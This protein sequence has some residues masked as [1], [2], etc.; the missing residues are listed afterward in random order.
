[1]E[2]AEIRKNINQNPND[3]Q[4]LRGAGRYYL[5]EG[6]YKQALTCFMQATLNNPHILPKILLDYET[7]IAQNPDKTGARLSLCG[8]LLSVENTDGALLELEELLEL[9]PKNVEAYN[10][11]GMIYVKREMIDEA[12]FLLE[13]SITEGVKDVRLSETLAS[14]YLEKGRVQDAISFYEEILKQK[15]GDKQTLRIL[16]ELYA[17]QEN[18]NFAARRYEAMFSG[19][20][21]VGREVIQRLEEMLKKVEG[22]V[23]IREILALIY[24]KAL[25]PEAAVE[26]LNEI[27]RLESTKA[28]TV[29]HQLKEVLKNYPNLP[30]AMLG[31]AEALRLKRIFSEAAETY[32]QL[33][34]IKPDFIEEIIGG[35]RKILEDCP[36]QVLARLYLGEALIRQ[37]KVV[38]ALNEFG[39]M[40]DS[41][42]SA[43]E[44]VIKKCRE[45]L[46][47]DPQLVKAHI[48]L[49][50]AYLAKE[51]FE[52]AAVEA[53]GVIALDKNATAAY[54]LLGEA[55]SRLNL[56]RKAFKSL[57]TALVLE[58][59]NYHI[60]AKIQEAR[61]KEIEADIES[62][63]QILTE[64]Q[65]K[66]S[67]HFDL[68]KL[69]IE[70][71]ERDTAVRELQLAQK[72]QLRAPAALNILGNLYRSEGKYEMAVAQ[73]NR[74]LETAVLD[75][76]RTIR[77]NLATAFEA[78]GQS[79]KALKIY[80]SIF[81]EDIDFGNLKN[82]IKQ[83]KTISLKSLRTYPLMAVIQK[84]GKKEIIALWGKDNSVARS[85][86]KEE[87]NVSFGQE[88]NQEGFE[89]FMKEMYPA[90]EEAFSLAVQLDRYFTVAINNLG[91]TLA[92]Q[93]KIEEAR[94]YLNSA[95]QIDP[96]SAILL[97]NLGVFCF[98]QGKEEPAKA[99]LE[100]SYALD[101]ESSGICINLGDFYYH[102]KESQKAIE[103]YRKVGAFD[104]LSD[105]AEQR[106]L[107]KIP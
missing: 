49:G 105:L 37:N 101:P 19:D 88:H 4:A 12:I 36:E 23:E 7:Q 63:K 86:K 14:A 9:D 44:T 48:I 11:L 77:F 28:D 20:P 71:G 41:D 3:P 95:T 69:Y 59:F 10:V 24:M 54:L 39:E 98:L 26:K 6:A 40:I 8:F 35:Y 30:S 67:A 84:F 104:P 38:E 60:H 102:H 94:L 57:H 90:A 46:R 55:Y 93:G 62:L 52:R 34:K 73:Y 74:A 22:N 68:A 100:K 97:N 13:K 106:L 75:T 80:E 82:R 25:N 91:V 99:F 85:G 5:A 29:I 33:F 1:M 87:I 96:T 51:D 76:S 18:F 89:Y 92:R 65:W 16:G 17:R 58:P 66:M 27:L 72:D 78:Q 32:F 45:I 64:D 31:L 47:G 50:R 2:L 15:P 53:E 83:L 56:L 70:K 103:L 61:T 107:Y 43:A 81:Q 21:E 42:A 79:R